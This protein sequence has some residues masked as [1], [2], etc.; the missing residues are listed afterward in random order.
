VKLR[1]FSSSNSHYKNWFFESPPKVGFQ[2]T[3]FGVF[4]TFG[5]GNTK[6]GFIMKIATSRRNFTSGF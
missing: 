2:K 1:H 5:A 4:G 3:N 6:I